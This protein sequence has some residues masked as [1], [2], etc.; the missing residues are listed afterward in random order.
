M[1]QQMANALLIQ[2]YIHLARMFVGGTTIDYEGYRRC[3]RQEK[4]H[5]MC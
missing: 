3:S 4:M 1:D 2:S 5:H